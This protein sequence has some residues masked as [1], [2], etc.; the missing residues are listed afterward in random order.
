MFIRP[1]LYA[2]NYLGDFYASVK[3]PL[4]FNG[5]MLLIISVLLIMLI[6]YSQERL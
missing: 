6:L 4:P 3:C 5:K 1:L 2:I